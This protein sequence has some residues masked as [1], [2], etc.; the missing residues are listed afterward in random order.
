[1]LAT[2]TWIM[3]LAINLNPLMRFDGYYV[4]SD[5]TGVEN[6]QERSNAMGRWKL[7]EI[8]FGYGKSAPEEGKRWLIPFSYA[9]W[10]YRLTVFFGICLLVYTYFFKALGVILAIA[11]VFRLLIMPLGRE[12]SLWWEWRGEAA[13]RYLIRSAVVLLAGVL[14]VALPVDDE[15][16]LPAYWQ[17][18]GVLTLYAPIAGRL[19]LLPA[20]YERKVNAGAPVVIITS[21]D[22]QYELEQAEHDVRT[23]K[24]QLE[25]TTMSA[26]LAQ[27]RLSLQAQL[28]GALEKKANIDM[29]L[30]DAHLLAPF[31]A[32]ITDV[33]PDLRPGDWVSK[34]D[35]LLT[36]INNRGGEVIA[37][38]E[39]SELN[40]LRDGAIG[41]F[42]PSGGSRPPQP[43][44][45]VEIEGFA[46]DILEQAY[47]AS[48]F[49]GH[50][51]VRDGPDG[52]L[53]PQRATYRVR[54]QTEAPTQDR[55][56]PG[57]LVLESESRSKLAMFWRQVVGVW[58]REAGV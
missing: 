37:F 49:G 3:T 42:Y 52:Q 29:Q 22:L 11:Q 5:S 43:V 33:Q 7:R 26:G 25:R 47:V 35:K 56:L 44:Q 51:D 20:S 28:S 1:M 31:D 41:R 53:V 36:L 39:E 38:L 50:L 18:S 58:R 21:P 12:V 10:M 6:L 32:W 57:L 46:L 15:L 14:W 27:N 54:L 9:V 48:T 19:E 4:L 40:A 45:L 24:Y 23:S 30:A 34:G 16:A 17:A 8:I 2:S 13:P 55:V